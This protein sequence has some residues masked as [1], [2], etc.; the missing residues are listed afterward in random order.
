M[1]NAFE[2]FDK[3]VRYRLKDQ[4]VVPQLGVSGDH[5]LVLRV[6]PEGGHET[7]LQARP[8][9][10]GQIEDRSLEQLVCE[11]GFVKRVDD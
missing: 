8:D 7:A 3:S 11:G 9:L 10:V 2:I 1:E 5:D 6:R 4:T